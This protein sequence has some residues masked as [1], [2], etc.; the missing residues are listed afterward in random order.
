MSLLSKK[1]YITQVLRTRCGNHRGRIIIAKP[2]FL[3]AIIE[4]IE[5]GFV[6]NNA[7]YLDNKQIAKLYED[8]CK[9]YEPN[10]K[11][12][13]II[14]PF[15]HLSKDSF[16]NIKWSGKPFKISPHAHS[17]SGKYLREN[18]EFAHL[19]SALWDLLQ[20]AN[21]RE[22]FREQIIDFFIRKKTN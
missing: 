6:Q 15:Y 18:V 19:D 4:A 11:P 12:S 20:D 7:I 13:P 14:L 1:Y 8:T 16:Y 5:K 21:V 9:K 22:E 10:Y 2:L 17:P 3:L